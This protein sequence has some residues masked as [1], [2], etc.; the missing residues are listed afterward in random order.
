MRSIALALILAVS[1]VV[2]QPA[3]EAQPPAEKSWRVGVLL[4]LYRPD[5]QPPQAFREHLR[6][7]GYVEGQHLHIEW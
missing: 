3:A 4:S 2:R 1:L 7:L 6:S 5:A